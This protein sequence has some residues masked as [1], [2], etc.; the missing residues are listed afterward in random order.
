MGFSSLNK[1]IKKHFTPSSKSQSQK[2]KPSSLNVQ[3]WQKSDRFGTFILVYQVQVALTPSLGV[4]T[5]T[6][7]YYEIKYYGSLVQY[8]Q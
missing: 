3:A 8:L 4:Y 1:T 6:L 5:T 7:Q 2:R